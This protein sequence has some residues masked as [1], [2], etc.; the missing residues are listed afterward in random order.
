M[1]CIGIGLVY[2]FIQAAGA[3]AV[4][5]PPVRSWT[6]QFQRQVAQEL[7]AA[8]KDS[9]MARVVMQSIGDRDIARACAK[10]GGQ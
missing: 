1:I 7:R 5:C 6:P 2:C 9:A 8:P 3:N 4:V 10:S